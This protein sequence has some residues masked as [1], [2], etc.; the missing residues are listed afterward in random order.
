MSQ[1]QWTRLSQGHAGWMVRCDRCG[2]YHGH[3]SGVTM[4]DAVEKRM[5]WHQPT[6][7]SVL[8]GWQEANT[9]YAGTSDRK[10]YSFTKDGK[11]GT[12]YSCDAAIYS[13]ATARGGKYVFAGDD[14]SSIYCFDRAGEH[15]WI[16]TGCGSTCS[17]QYFSDRL[18]LVTTSGYLTCIV[19]LQC[20]TTPR[21]LHANLGGL[22]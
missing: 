3:S 14:S 19:A 5:L 4:Y 20:K 11:A 10:V 6:R 9:V 17:M 22:F 2:I 1:S 12:V 13:R 21:Y 15:L 7:G 8:F 18:Y 16:G